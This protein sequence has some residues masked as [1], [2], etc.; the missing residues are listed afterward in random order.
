M[1]RFFG[2]LDGF[3]YALDTRYESVNGQRI[4]NDAE[5]QQY[6]LT[7]KQRITLDDETYFQAGYF[8]SDAGDI[9]AYYDPAM[10]NPGFRVQETQQ[11]TLLAG[12]HHT[13]SP[14]SHTLFLAGRLD[15]SL[16]YQNPQASLLFLRQS[17]GVTTEVQS[18]PAGPP[19]NL[20]FANEFT[21]YS[22][23]L[24]QIWESEH[25]SLVVGGRW[26]RG[27]LATHAD[28]SR[29]PQRGA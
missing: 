22:A 9:A 3:S 13:W 4:N 29:V 1:Y 25:Q 14:G 17:G 6:V 12:W 7:A 18:P 19:F 15:D 11:P 26:Q 23:E 27:D 2:T 8:K 5:R 28:L 16:S 21:L 24:Q 10:A 20:N